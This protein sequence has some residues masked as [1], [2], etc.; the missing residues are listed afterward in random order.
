LPSSA[1]KR[2]L[3]IR[4]WLAELKLLL[5][6]STPLAGRETIFVP[7]AGTDTVAERVTET[8]W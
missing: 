6:V 4:R 8:V 3:A 7:D 5:M 1:S 2:V